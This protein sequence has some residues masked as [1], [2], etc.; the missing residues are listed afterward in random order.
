MTP[1][2]LGPASRWLRGLRLRADDVLGGAHV[3]MIKHRLRP[4]TSTQVDERGH[5]VLQAGE[6][7]NGF[8][9]QALPDRSRHDSP[10]LP[11]V[12]GSPTSFCNLMMCWLID[13]GEYWR[14]AAVCCTEPLATTALQIASR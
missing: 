2:S 3:R 9:G 10:P 1:A 6:D 13:A 14:L 4:G 11:F 5:E 7:V 8:L 12:E